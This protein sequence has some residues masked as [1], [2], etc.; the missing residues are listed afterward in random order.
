MINGTN[1]EKAIQISVSTSPADYHREICDRLSTSDCW[2]NFTLVQTVNVICLWGRGNK[3]LT[4]KFKITTTPIATTKS[5]I[6]QAQTT[7]PKIEHKIYEIGPYVIRNTGQQQLLFNPEWSLKRIEVLMQTN[8]SEIQP[9]CS[10]FL[11]TSSEGWT[12]RLQKQVH[13]RGRMRRDLTGILGTGLGVLNGIDSE[14]L[15]NK[16]ATATNDLVKLRQPLQ[17]SLLALGTSQWE[18][19]K[20]LPKWKEA[21]DQDH[22][23]II[24][25]LNIAQNNV[26]LALSCIQAQLWIQSI[27][28]LV[29]REGNEGTFPIE[30]RKIV[31][32]NASNLERKLQSWWT[33]VNFTYDPTTEIAT[34]FVLTIRNAT[35]Y[36]IHPIIALGLNHEKTVLYP[37][38]H[39]AWARIMNEKW[40]TVNLES[41]VTREQ[42]GFIC[43][44][45]MIDAQD[46][47]L[48]TE[49]NICHFEIHPDTSQKTMLVYI[50]LGCDILIP[51]F[52]EDCQGMIS[53]EEKSLRCG[54]LEDLPETF[55]HWAEMLRQKVLSYQR[56]AD[57]Y[58]NFCLRGKFFQ[59]VVL[60]V[61]GRAD[62][63]GKT[64]AETLEI[65][66][67]RQCGWIHLMAEGPIPGEGV[68]PEEELKR[69][70][71]CQGEA[72]QV[73]P[74]T[75][76]GGSERGRGVRGEDVGILRRR[77]GWIH[78][79][80][81][82]PIPGEGVSPEEELKRDV[83]CQG[84]A[85]QVLKGPVGNP[86]ITV[87]ISDVCLPG[88]SGFDW[89]AGT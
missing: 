19:S 22:K 72:E 87:S 27:V 14:I 24:N 18:I 59:L 21:E 28:A 86:G 4:F 26:S 55:Q 61:Q 60:D 81:E 6:T 5:T 76:A 56:Q 65:G 67:L 42:Q 31:W 85:E 32:D 77:C 64:H 17:S 37:S 35:I 10:S 38:E 40:Q 44:T 58:Y 52:S 71:I 69:D 68:S 78:L 23:L 41:C 63:R 49:Q 54:M 33:L 47:C 2:Y 7:P 34:T 88:S 83:I 80:A 8:I 51:P 13:F 3:G 15:M 73:H 70:V 12:T 9:A 1:Y 11:R 74:V 62:K 48:D 25:A 20:I 66:A 46:I 82:G 30:I 53:M 89:R 75:T 57:D 43:D 45:N 79:I 16:L 36:N 39:R 50:G 29:V 84:E